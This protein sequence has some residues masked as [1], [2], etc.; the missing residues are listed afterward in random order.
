MLLIS[1]FNEVISQLQS[2]G[3]VFLWDHLGFGLSAKPCHNWTYS[4][5]EHA[6]VATRLLLDLLP[7]HLDTGKT[8]PLILVAHDMGD[9]VATE[10]LARR[11]RG[12][13]P[14]ALNIAGVV[15]TNGGMHFPLSRFR[16]SQRALLSPLGSFLN[17][18]SAAL[19]PNFVLSRQQLREIWGPR[20]PPERRDAAIDDL[21][22]FNT[23]RDGHRQ[24][25]RSIN[26][27]RDRFD[28]NYRWLDALS[29]LDL[30]CMLLWG[31]HDAVAPLTIAEF[32]VGH[33]APQCSLHTLGDV[34][35]FLMLE[36]PQQWLQHVVEFAEAHVRTGTIA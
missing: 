9:S 29:A 19:D 20:D 24:L 31:T 36:A 6:D 26:Y 7:R 12:L 30:P 3:N 14:A 1:D 18:L 25:Y 21:V 10:I 28:F 17:G 34:G 11:H 23:V 22:L 8:S 32:I 4:I 16:L 13:L 2:K 27:L 33:V 35:H 5:F 15:F